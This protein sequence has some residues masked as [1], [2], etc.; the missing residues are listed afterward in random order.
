MAFLRV[1]DLVKRFDSVVAVDRVSFEIEKGEFLTLLGP[2]GCGKTTTLRCI[3]GLETVENGEIYIGDRLMVSAKKNIFVEPHQRGLG[4][5]F[6]SYAIWPHLTVFDNVAYPLKERKLPKKEIRDKVGRILEMVRLSG[7][8]DRPATKLSGGQQQR[9]ALARALVY[10]PEVLLFDEPLSNLDAKLRIEMRNEIRKLQQD[11]H[12]TSLYVTHDQEEAFALSDRII[13]MNQGRIEQIG[14]PFTLY[15]NPQTQFVAEFI[16]QTNFIE[17]VIESSDEKS[18][19]VRALGT[20]INANN[21]EKFNKGDEVIL[22]IR[23]EYMKVNPREEFENELE[24]TVEQRQYVGSS[25]R[26][27]LRVGGKGIIVDTHG[28]TR[29]DLKALPDE[30]DKVKLGFRAED[31][32]LFKARE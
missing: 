18:V 16:G 3:A 25:C 1:L 4:M 12:I 13:V 10:D 2:S 24:G 32:D 7:L 26:Y 21:G 8:E 15:F 9:V 6:Q 17:G 22:S 20:L 30:G 29:A 23:P 31:C 19:R 11:L 27:I 5:V 14:D 28:I